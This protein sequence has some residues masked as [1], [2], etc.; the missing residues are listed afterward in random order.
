GFRLINLVA[1]ALLLAAA[2]LPVIAL[3]CWH[4]P[5]IRRALLAV[6][7]V[8]AVGCVMH[9]LVDDA[10]RVL[11]LTGTHQVRYPL[12]EWITIDRHAAD[13]QDLALNEPWF[14]IEGLLWGALGWIALG[15]SP[16]RRRWVVSAVGAVAVLTTIGVLS[17]FGVIGRFVV[18]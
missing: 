16:A 17:A 11:S 5:G 3:F 4:R 2:A 8:V 18:G 15:R 9:A 14:L 10:Q 13:L 7:W 6:C 1:A 12:S